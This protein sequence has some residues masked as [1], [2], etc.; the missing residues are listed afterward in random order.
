MLFV[1]NHG[2]D[3]IEGEG[4]GWY[5]VSE[6]H[7]ALQHA[8]HLLRDCPI[9][10][11][12]IAIIAPFAAQ[13][14]L[15]RSL[16]RSPQYYLWA[17]NIGPLEAFQG[18]ES[19]AVILCTTR[20]RDRFL[21]QDL[22]HGFGV[23][24]EAKRFNVALTRARQALIVIGNAKLLAGADGNWKTFLAFC[25]RNGLCDERAMVELDGMES[26]VREGEGEVDVPSHVSRLETALLYAEDRVQVE[27]EG[28]GRGQQDGGSMRF[29]GADQEEAMY[30]SA[31]AA[32]AAL[33]EE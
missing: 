16:A 19:R 2:L 14:R 12:D 24:R 3:E 17:I 25:Q 4:G 15:L 32:E 22:A 13:V 27:D 23:I 10:Q 28:S 11:K 6:A 21:D 33:R 8:Q 30:A 26:G 29:G 9:E 7:L 5:N 18:L 1:Q 31:L 20:T